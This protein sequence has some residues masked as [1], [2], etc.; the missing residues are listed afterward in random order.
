MAEAPKTY[1]KPTHPS[2]Q[3]ATRRDLI[4]HAA[5]LKDA[6]PLNADGTT[7]TFADAV[8]MAYAVADQALGQLDA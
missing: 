6:L 4:A 8:V 3:P 1:T 5:L 2:M 7:P